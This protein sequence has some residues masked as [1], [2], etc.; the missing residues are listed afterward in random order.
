MKSVGRKMS[1]SMTHHNQV[2]Q[3]ENASKFR[4]KK[5]INALH[6]GLTECHYR[7]SSI[8]IYKL[9]KVPF[10]FN[11]KSVGWKLNKRMLV[12]L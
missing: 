1:L 12:S 10:I 9:T 11:E 8:E 2:S 6:C 7:K 5:P 3:F 4:E